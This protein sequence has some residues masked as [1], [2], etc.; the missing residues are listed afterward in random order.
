MPA[1][2]SLKAFNLSSSLIRLKASTV[3]ILLLKKATTGS[4]SETEELSRMLL[5]K[6][7][8]KLLCPKLADVSVMTQSLSSPDSCSESASCSS[9]P[10]SSSK[11]PKC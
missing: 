2:C 7:V 1:N 4:S 10:C 6:E 5:S 8:S 9:S 3:G 11:E